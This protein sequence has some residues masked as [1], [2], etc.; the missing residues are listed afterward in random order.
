MLGLFLS[1][2]ATVLPGVPPTFL[3]SLLHCRNLIPAEGKERAELPHC[4]PPPPLPQGALQAA[5]RGRPSMPSC[6]RLLSPSIPSVPHH[7]PGSVPF[8]PALGKSSPSQL[9]AGIWTPWE[10]N[11]KIYCQQTL[12]GQDQICKPQDQ[13]HKPSFFRGRR[14]KA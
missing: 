4:H 13:T 3:Q 1:Q 9:L 6:Q 2:L 14:G 12:E 5:S 7:A 10:N 8:L 11:S